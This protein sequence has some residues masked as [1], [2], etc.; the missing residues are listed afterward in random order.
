MLLY[1][2]LGICYQKHQSLNI[3]LSSTRHERMLQ[4]GSEKTT[5]QGIKVNV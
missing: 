3:I 5:F 2:N 1:T 4:L